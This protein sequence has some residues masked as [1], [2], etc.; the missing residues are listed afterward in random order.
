MKVEDQ[1]DQLILLCAFRY[2][3]GR[4]TYMPGVV[5]AKLERHWGDLAE[6]HRRQIQEEVRESI[7]RGRAGMEC[8]IQVWRRLLELP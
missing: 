4:M 5:A 2:S 7:E 8:D 3:L 6:G 1:D